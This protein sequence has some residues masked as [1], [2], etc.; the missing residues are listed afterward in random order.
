V[1]SAQPLRDY[2]SIS[3]KLYDAAAGHV[4]VYGGKTTAKDLKENLI[5]EGVYNGTTYVLA[6]EEYTLTRITLMGENEVSAE[7][8]DETAPLLSEIGDEAELPV[9]SV[10]AHTSVRNAST[11]S[12]QDIASSR[13]ALT[14]AATSAYPEYR[15]IKVTDLSGIDNDYSADTIKNA[16]GF[17]VT[18]GESPIYNREFYTVT[19]LRMP[20]VGV[21]GDEGFYTVALV[22]DPSISMQG[23][24]TGVRNATLLNVT[25]EVKWTERDSTGRYYITD[26]GYSAFV[27]GMSQEEIFE[28]LILTAHY[29]NS[30]REVGLQFSDTGTLQ[31][32]TATGETVNWNGS[33]PSLDTA[34]DNL[35]ISLTVTGQSA[36]QQ[37]RYASVIIPLEASRVVS[38]AVEEGFV[39]S[40]DTLYATSQVPLS[41]FGSGESGKIT[42]TLNSGKTRKLNSAEYTTTDRLAPTASNF[43][44]AT[45]S[46]TVKIYYVDGSNVT[47]IFTPFTFPVTNVAIR[48]AGS[49]FEGEFTTQTLRRPFSFAGLSVT[50]M[51]TNGG[52]V[53][54][55]L[56]D[57]DDYDEET[58]TFSEHYVQVLLKD[59]DGTVL[60][61]ESGRNLRILNSSVT[62]ATVNFRYAYSEG[63]E[64]EWVIPQ[65]ATVTKEQ[66]SYNSF[67]L[68]KLSFSNP[69]LSTSVVDYSESLR[70]EGKP[71]AFADDLDEATK[72]NL[73]VSVYA[74]AEC[75]DAGSQTTVKNEFGEDLAK[76]EDGAVKF[77]AGGTYYVRFQIGEADFGE[78]QWAQPTVSAITRSTDGRTLV[79]KIEINKGPISLRVQYENEA[80]QSWTYG[81]F[82]AP[83]VIG[84]PFGAAQGFELS[85]DEYEL[86]YYRASDGAVFDY[87]VDVGG[88]Y[89]VARTN[90]SPAYQAA[91]SPLPL[92][93]AP[94][95]TI[96]PAELDLTQVQSIIFDNDAHGVSEF[97]TAIG[98]M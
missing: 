48:G 44:D 15:T 7:I 16:P 35:S 34:N 54:I 39:Y 84:T 22:S 95:I 36:S 10:V 55:P 51:Y 61:D 14:A 75:M 72:E 63:T 64:N 1:A 42:A 23:K 60:K 86:S 58:G 45:Y 96:L 88:Y 41:I 70:T 12:E 65:D 76:I 18:D 89:V 17:Q 74:T 27:A 66:N 80:A 90:E 67:R 82:K 8:T 24:I 56:S 5:V 11:G 29:K 25:L 69:S 57:F 52:R 19:E 73:N 33:Q 47:D 20:S 93:G 78:V 92:S 91:V 81:Q 37:T 2:T 4:L 83:K 59:K 79:Y 77:Y 53:T 28:S 68:E 87:P 32:T 62:Q 30:S 13:I 98:F 26:D 43:E 94:E 50:I 31:T 3:A 21:I 97:I 85:A 71:F 40:G 6:P 46:K 49:F 9:I 38:I